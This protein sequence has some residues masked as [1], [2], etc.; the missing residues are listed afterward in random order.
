M[1]RR[2]PEPD[3]L[4]EVVR[5]FRHKYPHMG[6]TLAEIGSLVCPDK[7]FPRSTIHYHVGKLL[8]S[9]QLEASFIGG[10]MVTRSLRLPQPQE[11]VS[12]CSE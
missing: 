12:E 9:G 11:P 5:M 7:P 1:K 8:E 10:A 6:P 2:K 3:D 4:I